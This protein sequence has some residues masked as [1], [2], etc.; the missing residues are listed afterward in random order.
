MEKGYYQAG[1]GEVKEHDMWIMVFTLRSLARKGI[2]LVEGISK[3]LEYL[4]GFYCATKD[5]KYLDVAL[6]EIKAY[7][8]MGGKYFNNYKQFDEILKEKD[9][10]KKEFLLE[11]DAVQINLNRNQI[12]RLIRKWM[13]SKDNP[14][15]IME[16]ADDIINKV[17]NKE[18]GIYTYTYKSYNAKQYD[19]DLYELIVEDDN[20]Y[21]HDVALMQYYIFRN[22]E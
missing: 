22:M 20:S 11:Y 5:K 3:S 17:L 2:P 4:K 10:E 9:I 12:T 19:V 13:P 6:L 14:M 21:F 8:I 7:L 15:K 1:D 18:V 16:V